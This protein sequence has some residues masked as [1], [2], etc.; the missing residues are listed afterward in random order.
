M[1]KSKEGCIQMATILVADDDRAVLNLCQK[2]LR[3]G[4]HRVF[5]AGGGEEAMSLLQLMPTT[6]DLALLDIMMP[7]ATGIQL[8]G[9][10]KATNPN[11]PIILMT[12]YSFRE[13]QQIVGERNPFRIIWKP[14]KTDALLRMIDNAFEGRTAA[15]A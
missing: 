12:G 10:I 4:G 13:I 2:I 15:S 1:V 14:F 5:S 6:I 11:I 7:G 9:R 3:L 8:A